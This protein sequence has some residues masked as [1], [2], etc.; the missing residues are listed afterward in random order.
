M[1]PDEIR[2][3]PAPLGLAAGR[4]PV[5]VTWLGTAGFAIEHEGFVVLIDPYLTRASLGQCARGALV[6]DPE[7]LA[8]HVSRADA[9]V[10]GHAHFDHVLDV[11]T[12][13]R[14]TGAR[15]FGSKSCARLCRA[16]GVPQGQVV[17]V[18]SSMGQSP[19]E[20]EVGPFAL[21]FV[22]SAHSA[23]ALGRVPF[24]GEIA[25]CPELPLGVHEYRCGAVFSV[26]L[27]VAGRRLYHLGSAELIDAQARPGVDLLMLCVAGWTTTPRFAP[28]VLSAL[29]PG[30]VLLSHWDNFFQPF[31]R[32]AAPLP[33]MKMGALVDALSA[34]SR[35]LAVGTLD[36]FGS[37][38]L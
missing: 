37:L 32:G 9:I 15:V 24:E 34:Q 1:R 31:S 36:H 16:A 25:D 13:A 19:V 21:R 33:A 29:D 23:F 28:R 27:R 2:F 6:S 8:A 18:E 22:P 3:G 38:S 20:A 11:P 5:R 14:V 35:G 17:D 7:V 26:D 12:L 4:G 10:A 30:V